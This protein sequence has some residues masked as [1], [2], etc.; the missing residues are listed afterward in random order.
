MMRSLIWFGLA[1][2]LAA[3]LSA[4]SRPA[5]APVTLTVE[6][7]GKGSVSSA[8]AG[9]TAC[10]G[11]CE[12][13]F[14]LGKEVT[15]RATPAS[16]YGL[17]AWSVPACGEAQ[18]CAVQLNEAQTVTVTFTRSYTLTVTRS[19]TGSGRVVGEGKI[20]CPED[21][22]GSYYQGAV[23]VLAAEPAAGSVFAGWGGACAAAQAEPSCELTV[24][25][26]A[27]VEAAF[28]PQDAS[29]PPPRLS[30]PGDQ[31][32]VQNTGGPLALELPFT[33][34]DADD[35]V[36]AL[37]IGASSDAPALTGEPAVS[38]AA[39][40]DCTLVLSVA[41]AA[42]DAAE[43]TLTAR[44]PEGAEDET[45]FT[46]VVA[47]RLVTSA[48]D[49]G[50]GSLRQT[51]QE[52]EP[53]DV[54]AFDTE[55]AFAVPQ[56]IALESQLSLQTSLT[57]QG[58]GQARLTL[59]GGGASRHLVVERGVTARLAGLTLANGLGQDGTGSTLSNSVGG[60]V[61]NR[62]SLTLADVTLTGNR[63]ER[64]GAVYNAA[65]AALTLENAAVTDNEADFS[66]GA[67]FNDSQDFGGALATTTLTLR[68]STFSGNRAGSYGGVLY[69]YKPESVVVIEES[70]FE[71]NQ[72]QSSSAIGN[73]A[74]GGEG[75]PEI[76][77]NCVSEAGTL[78]VRGA[79]FRDNRSVQVDIE[80]GNGALSN[81]GVL[82]LADS[83]FSGNT[84][85]AGAALY[86]QFRAEA[87]LAGVAFSGNEAEQNAGAIY[88][89]GELSFAQDV[90][91]SDNR[92]GLNGGGIFNNANVGTVT[93][94]AGEGNLVSGNTADN[95]GGG[96]YNGGPAAGVAQVAAETVTGNLPNDIVT[97]PAESAL[98]LRP[99]R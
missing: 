86:N 27:E 3:L 15:L 29:N 17:T 82:T 81:F 87:T 88:N 62:G 31:R 91:V 95:T 13:G 4:C 1:V 61:V 40:G 67:L 93:I 79:T 26:D 25:A 24:T 66:G 97:G 20:D 14:P 46:L 8:P 64:G 53:F 80:D 9:I 33:V 73:G 92:A 11:T 76:E 94:P 34:S 37:V 47:P 5:S 30:G 71:G 39:A 69:T 23:A 57:L 85:P 7:V 56:T 70:V 6:V 75:C 48:A 59:D 12:A 21:C 74:L 41:R 60:A 78:S 51:L 72:A 36:S 90:T 89:E 50:A 58:P 43:V 18:S 45:R 68:N 54:L 42:A 63:A 19:G 55:G 32:V 2:A 65:G 99:V 10:T 16:G 52:S 98:P 84:A 83:T 35:A 77:Q 44:D 38:C 28:A 96:I 22:Q 49:A